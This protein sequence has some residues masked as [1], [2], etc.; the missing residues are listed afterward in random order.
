[1]WKLKISR[2]LRSW[3]N[4][5]PLAP[6]ADPRDLWAIWK[7]LGGPKGMFAK[8]IQG[9]FGFSQKISFL[10]GGIFSSEDLGTGT[11]EETEL[12]GEKGPALDAEEIL[13][14]WRI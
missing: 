7:E 5:L 14:G 1:M 2:N 4:G 3:T 12:P 10:A 9:F 8:N 11:E 13:Q 6:L